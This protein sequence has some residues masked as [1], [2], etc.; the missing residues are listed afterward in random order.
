M[1]LETDAIIRECED[2]VRADRDA[3]AR[4]LERTAP[5]LGLTA[6]QT[7]ALAL[8]IRQGVHLTRG[9]A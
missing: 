3:I 1:P 7:L 9:E 6:K 5:K 2:A 8:S 4:F